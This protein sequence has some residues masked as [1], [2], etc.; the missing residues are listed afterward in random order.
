LTEKKKIR[1]KIVPCEIFSR[2][3]GYFRPIECWNKGKLEE[4][5]NRALIDPRKYDININS[6]NENKNNE[7]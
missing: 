5:H 4:F 3:V 1:V 2:V 6:S 7:I